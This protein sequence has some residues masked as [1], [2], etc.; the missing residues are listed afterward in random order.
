M[1]YLFQ[2]GT[3]LLQ[4]PGCGNHKTKV[5]YSRYPTK[6][7]VNAGAETFES[8]SVHLPLNREYIFSLDFE[9][10]QSLSGFFT[11]FLVCFLSKSNHQITFSCG[12][13]KNSLSVL[14]CCHIIQL[15]VEERNFSVTT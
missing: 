1:L 15:V 11:I 7:V 10:E 3:A 4:L 12:K 14:F 6:F 5:G 2:W 13:R 8:I 9:N